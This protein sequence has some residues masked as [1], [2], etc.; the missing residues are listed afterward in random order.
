MFRLFN[1]FMLSMW[2]LNVYAI[3]VYYPRQPNSLGNVNAIAGDFERTNV[4]KDD[5]YRLKS[6]EKC[7]EYARAAGQTTWIMSGFFPIPIFTECKKIVNSLTFDTGIAKANEFPHMAAIGWVLP[8]HTIGYYCGG[9]LISEKWIMTA[10]HCTHGPLGKPAVVLL[11]SNR[12]SDTRTGKLKWI[13]RSIRHPAYNPPSMYADLALLELARRVYFQPN[14]K[15]ACLHV[16]FDKTPIKVWVTGWGSTQFDD[17]LSDVL[18][19]AELE[20]I[21]NVRC[22]LSYNS[23]TSVPSGVV[24]SMICAGDPQGGWTKDTCRGDSGGPLQ[25]IHPNGCLYELIGVTS[26]GKGCGS[27]GLPGVYTRVSHY[28]EWI[29]SVV[30]PEDD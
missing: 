7:E 16:E 15:P 21:D 6:V 29:E 8:D 19:K 10:A 9:S 3:P 24:P 28:V 23:S 27:S 13:K 22:S 12:L 17:E 5:E 18:I 11:G 30:W 14:I 4:Y 2:T 25:S 20:V 26:F 1:L